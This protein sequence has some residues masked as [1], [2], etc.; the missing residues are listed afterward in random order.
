MKM[1]KHWWLGFLGFIGLYKLPATMT[2]FTGNES[3]FVLVNLLWLFWFLEFLP[4]SKTGDIAEENE[5]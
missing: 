4:P 5:K 2:Y 3:V 1:K